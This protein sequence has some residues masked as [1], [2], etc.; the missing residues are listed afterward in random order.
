VRKIY[1]KR[2][3]KNIA[4]WQANKYA[5]RPRMAAIGQGLQTGLYQIV[6]NIPL[7][8][9]FTFIFAGGPWL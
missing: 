8:R 5:L 9:K 2:Q 1:A 4:T 7:Q 3:R 6:Q